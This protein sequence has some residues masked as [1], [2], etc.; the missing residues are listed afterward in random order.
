MT[1][2]NPGRI[3]D[4]RKLAN[5]YLDDL[6]RQ[7]GRLEKQVDD[8]QGELRAE[9]ERVA[10][11]MRRKDVLLQGAQQQIALLS[12]RLGLLPAPKS[13]GATDKAPPGLAPP[14]AETPRTVARQAPDKPMGFRVP[15]WPTLAVVGAA[16]R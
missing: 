3:E 16:L 2:T 5:A 14:A 13:R 6:R 11:E 10:E 4:V 1:D 15:G 7:I 8:L 9:R 12:E